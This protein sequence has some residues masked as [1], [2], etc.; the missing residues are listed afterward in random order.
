MK[1]KKKRKKNHL[2]SN[3]KILFI[4]IKWSMNIQTKIQLAQKRKKVK[5]KKKT[6]I[7]TPH[8]NISFFYVKIQCYSLFYYV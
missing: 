6:Q 1:T 7:R 3:Q 8:K 5:N 2:K 4:E